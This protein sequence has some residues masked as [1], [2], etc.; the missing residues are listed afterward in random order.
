MLP[1]SPLSPVIMFYLGVSYIRLNWNSRSCKIIIDVKEVVKGTEKK[2]QIR[3]SILRRQ[4]RRKHFVFMYAV[5]TDIKLSL[6]LNSKLERF[7]GVS[8]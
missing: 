2:I 4:F 1:T 6:L 5:I 8:F 3:N 7:I